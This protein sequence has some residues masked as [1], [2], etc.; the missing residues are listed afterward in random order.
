MVGSTMLGL[1]L[2]RRGYRPR[3]TGWLLAL[4]VPLSVVIGLFTS[5]GSGALPEMFAFGIA[6]HLLA[7]SGEV[8]VATE[9]ATLRSRP[10]HSG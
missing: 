9:A 6:G 3:V 5:M 10:A 4:S 8:D 7:R 1:T 2:V